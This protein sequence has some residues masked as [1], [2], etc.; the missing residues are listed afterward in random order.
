MADYTEVKI[1]LGGQYIADMPFGSEFEKIKPE[2]HVEAVYDGEPSEENIRDL[3]E[4]L[5]ILL[6]QS[7]S[8]LLESYADFKDYLDE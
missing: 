7:T 1:R 8:A 6:E 2:A 3:R 5:S 4:R